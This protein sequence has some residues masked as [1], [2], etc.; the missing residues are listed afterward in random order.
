MGSCITNIHEIKRSIDL[1][2]RK[3][4]RHIVYLQWL[5]DCFIEATQVSPARQAVGFKVQGTEIGLETVLRLT[6]AVV[7]NTGGRRRG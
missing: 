7:Q 2:L 3:I 6:H 1:L 4:L 5:G